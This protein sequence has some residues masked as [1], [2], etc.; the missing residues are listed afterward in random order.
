MIDQGTIKTALREGLQALGI[1]KPEQYVPQFAC[2]IQTLHKWNQAYNLTAVREADEMVA[3]HILDSCAVRPSL[4][5]REIL[6]VG[7]GA[8]LPGIPLALL[9]P[10]RRFTLLDSNGKK[11]RFLTQAIAELGLTNVE[12]VQSRVEEFAPACSYDS[13][14]CRA[15]TS[16][17]QFVLH[18]EKFL[19]PAGRLIAMK[20]KLPEQEL[21]A[22]PSGWQIEVAEVNVPGLAA[23]RRLIILKRDN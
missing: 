23:E 15:F 16:I 4:D 22:V 6:D 2:F 18:C 14:L 7:T 9:E 5:G 13:I 1:P 17:E 20:G 12:V 11:T 21:L 8:G 19:Q 10:D 3:K